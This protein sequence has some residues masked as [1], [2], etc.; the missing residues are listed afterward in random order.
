MLAGSTSS[1]EVMCNAVAR[2]HNS[3]TIASQVDID[4]TVDDRA[5]FD[6]EAK[7]LEVLRT[8]LIQKSRE[9]EDFRLGTADRNQA[10]VILGD[11]VLDRGV[12][13]GNARTKMALKG[14]SGLGAEHV[15]GKQVTDIIAAPQKEEPALVRKAIGRLDDVPDYDEKASIR[16]DL[17]ARVEQQEALLATR[18]DGA[19]ALAKLKSEAAKLIVDGANML[20]QAKAALEGRF[21]RQKDYVSSF[22]LD[23]G[24]KKR[25][26]KT[27]K[28]EVKD[29]T[30]GK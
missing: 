20:V 9:I 17:I 29:E 22:F 26:K 23:V 16:S 30:A 2:T 28:S 7:K 15:F 27:E 8:A 19:E 1:L 3:L 25:G 12:S 13:R 24:K 14:T 21:P 10:A 18:E 6:V 5:F 4:R 11:T